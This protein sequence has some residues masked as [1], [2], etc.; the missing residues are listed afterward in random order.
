MSSVNTADRRKPK[1]LTGSLHNGDSLTQEEF[2]ELYSRHSDDTKFELIGGTVYMASPLRREHGT[3]H[4]ELSGVLWLYKAATPGVESADNMTT[5][6]S[7]KAEPQPDL[8][9]RLLTEYGGQTRY[10]EANYLVGA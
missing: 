1:A 4:L 3:A 7:P 6:L 10:N 8:M 9:L 5:I 2:H